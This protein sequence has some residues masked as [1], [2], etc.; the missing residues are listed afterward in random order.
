V[1]IRKHLES[2]ESLV[3]PCAWDDS[4]EL[5]DVDKREPRPV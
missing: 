2:L 4:A 5:P 3:I 1:S